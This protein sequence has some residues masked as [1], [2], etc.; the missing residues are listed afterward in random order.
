M[1]S[2]FS[3]QPKEAK[4]QEIVQAAQDPDDG[5]TSADAQKVL[6]DESKKGGAAA[7]Q[8]DPDASPAEKAAQTGAVSFALNAYI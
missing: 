3:S 4:Q 8:F 2:Q 1:F 7:F 5:V 6:L